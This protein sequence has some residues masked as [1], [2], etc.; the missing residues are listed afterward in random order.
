MTENAS[1]LADAIFAWG[2]KH[3]LSRD[4]AF[5]LIEAA[6]S[7]EP[8]GFE[9]FNRIVDD[10]SIPRAWF[11]DW[12]ANYFMCDVFPEWSEEQLRDAI[13]EIGLFLEEQH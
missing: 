11:E 6:F 10:F 9:L 5:G 1:N 13:I 3:G 2:N 7:D 4:K 8:A 12:D